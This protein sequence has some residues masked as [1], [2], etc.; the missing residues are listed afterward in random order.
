MAKTEKVT[1]V[2]DPMVKKI[3]PEEEYKKKIP[4]LFN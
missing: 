3:I 4:F 2:W 1:L